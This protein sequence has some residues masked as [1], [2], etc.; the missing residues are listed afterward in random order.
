[1]EGPPTPAGSSAR[2][3]WASPLHT[4]GGGGAGND[5]PA[6]E[7]TGSELR[8]ALSQGLPV[9]EQNSGEGQGGWGQGSP[10]TRHRSVHG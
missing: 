10:S 8:S 5:G 4:L 3:G 9:P 6:V 1:M 2:W 7:K